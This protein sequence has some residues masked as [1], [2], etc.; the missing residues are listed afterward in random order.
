MNH[1]TKANSSRIE[2]LEKVKS[3][4][5]EFSGSGRRNYSSE[6]KSLAVSAVELG[7]GQGVVSKAS[8]VSLSS[9]NKWVSKSRKRKFRAKPLRLIDQPPAILTEGKSETSR[10]GIRIRLVS[11][12][13]IELSGRELS[14]ELLN[15]LS[16]VSG[17]Q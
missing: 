17:R 10:A 1:Q 14:P 12:V 9:I 8:G 16:T 13:E 2:I 15:M 6:I 5:Q 3:E 11:G 7:L 4:F